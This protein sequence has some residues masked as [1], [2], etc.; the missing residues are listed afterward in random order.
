MLKGS[1][2]ACQSMNNQTLRMR[3]LC[4]GA[5]AGIAVALVCAV[6][7][8]A[9]VVKRT[10]GAKRR[11][12]L[13][14]DPSGKL[15]YHAHE[16]NQVISR[17]NAASAACCVDFCLSRPWRLHH[18]RHVDHTMRLQQQGASLHA[19]VISLLWHDTSCALCMHFAAA[20]LGTR[21]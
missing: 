4:A 13:A 12:E 8:S 9:Y 20:V 2:K 21:N 3:V 10:L 19:G 17:N 6:V 5:I 15:A 16:M 1:A 11:G 14:A 7:L 18:H